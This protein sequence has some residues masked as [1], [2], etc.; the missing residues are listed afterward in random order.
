[1]NL[2]KFLVTMNFREGYI[3]EHVTG[4]FDSLIHIT[5]NGQFQV[6]V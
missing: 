3:L 5:S 4:L 2:R 1:M 6:S